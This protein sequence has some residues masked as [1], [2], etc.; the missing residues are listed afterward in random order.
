MPI[1]QRSLYKTIERIGER[2][3]DSE[4]A[5]LSAVLDEIIRND[6]INISGGRMWKLEANEKRYLLVDE[7][8]EIEHND[9]EIRLS[10]KEYRVF[11]EVARM[12][13][14]LADETNKTLLQHGVI[15]YS[16]TGIGETVSIDDLNYYEYILAFNTRGHDK[17]FKYLLSIAGQAT[18]HL[19]Q[20]RRSK[21]EVQALQSELTHARDMQKRILPEHEFHFGDYE[22]Y[23]I[24]LPEKIVGG[25]FFNYYHIPG[26]DDRMGVAIGDAASKGLPAAVQALFVSGALMMSVESE[27]M[28]SSTLKRLN[29]INMEMFPNDRI[30]TLFFCQLYNGP[31]G[32]MLYSNAGHSGPIHYHAS[33]K[34]CDELSVTGPVFGLL[35]DAS[36][37]ISNRNLAPDDILVLYTDGITEANDGETEFGEQR[38]M[39]CIKR[40]AGESAKNLAQLIL[41]EVQL[42]SANGVYSD[43][44]TVVVIKRKK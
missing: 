9:G 10:I 24:C 34:S 17:T 31:E 25:D 41:E 30:L 40:H 7:R 23:G 19:L 1:T 8:G 22:L 44:K 43:D 42:Y 16:A 21:S 2:S 27:A 4:E 33:S 20:N 6:R 38:L 14:V 28:M 15:K 12:R 11:G 37:G 3:Y 5:L 39:D 18:T 29:M 13:T 36:Y 32:L 26:F 35:E